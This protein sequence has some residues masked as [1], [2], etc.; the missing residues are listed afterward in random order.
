MGDKKIHIKTK[1]M[2]T[3]FPITRHLVTCML[4][5]RRENYDGLLKE[6]IVMMWLLAHNFQFHWAYEM[7]HI[8]FKFQKSNSVGTPYRRLTTKFLIKGDQ[9]G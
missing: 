1:F 4:L 5:P 9:F 7:I 3:S 8:M 6:N 2:K